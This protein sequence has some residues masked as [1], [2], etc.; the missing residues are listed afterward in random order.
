MQLNA[1]DLKDIPTL[2]DQLTGVD[3]AYFYEVI[4]E[5]QSM[6]DRVDSTYLMEVIDRIF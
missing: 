4:N 2:R 5:V 1:L 3:V 6:G